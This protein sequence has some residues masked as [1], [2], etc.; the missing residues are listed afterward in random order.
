MVVRRSDFAHDVGVVLTLHISLRIRSEYASS[1]RHRPLLCP[2]VHV[3]PCS[4]LRQG[5]AYVSFT[6]LLYAA[7]PQDLRTPDDMWTEV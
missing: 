7:L 5:A 1:S 4:G 2:V 6:H 3:L